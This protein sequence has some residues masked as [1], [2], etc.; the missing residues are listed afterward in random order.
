VTTHRA[1]ARTGRLALALT[2]ALALAACSSSGGSLHGS[3]PA[4]STSQPTAPDFPASSSAPGSTS[5]AAATTPGAPDDSGSRVIPAPATPVRTVTAQDADGVHHVVKIWAERADSTCYDHAYGQPIIS[6]LTSHPCRGMDRVLATT[7][8]ADGRA[9]GFSLVNASFDG[10]PQDPYADA[11]AFRTL[12]DKDGTGSIDDLLR[13][14]Y[15]LP[16]GP[17]RVPSPDAFA[18]LS[19]DNGVSVYDLWYL[20]GPTPYNDKTLEKLAEGIFLQV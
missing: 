14:G 6:F 17:T 18:C 1:A 5:A 2:A 20:D 8:T 13:E 19:Q 16:S 4:P 11:G 10:T 7:T 9:V 12:V 15:R 3:T